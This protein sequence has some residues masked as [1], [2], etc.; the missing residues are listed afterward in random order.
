MKGLEEPQVVAP[1]LNRTD[2]VESIATAIS[3]GRD[4]VNRIVEFLSVDMGRCPDSA[5]TPLVPIDDDLVPMS[6]SI[7]HT[8]PHRNFLSILQR[9]PNLVGEAGRLLGL[10]GEQETIDVL[11]RLR[12]GTRIARRVKVWRPDG[13]QAG[14]LD[15]VACDP[16]AK[17]I[18]AMEV[19]WGLS[20]DGNEE[21][22]RIEAGA[23]EKR[24][25]VAA[26]REAVLRG[27]VPQW[28]AEWPDVRGFRWRWFM[29]TRD[30]LPMRSFDTDGVTIRSV[31]LLRYTLKPES[32][33]ETLCALLDE[34]PWP[35]A[36]LRQTHW[37][38]F[39]YGDVKVEIEQ[40]N[41]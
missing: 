23:I 26:L 2:L 25:Q 30:V 8:S 32:S 24:K 18:V 40:I 3:S 41:A 28:P 12:T 7:M 34:P 9:D 14:D 37:N 22:H 19:R 33:L 10:A 6:V 39:R 4:E 38:S 35:P 11:K 1:R 16:A 13:S 29:L 31:Q 36:E 27:A 17:L 20:A 5:L 21:V 15:V